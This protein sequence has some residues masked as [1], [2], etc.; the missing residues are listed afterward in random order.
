MR[1]R[2]G[3]FEF[4]GQSGTFLQTE[5]SA[6]TC[7]INTC[8]HI[9]GILGITDIKTTSLASK[10]T[11]TCP[12]PTQLC[13]LLTPHFALL[14]CT[15][16]DIHPTKE[17]GMRKVCRGTAAKFALF[18]FHWP[19][20]MLSFLQNMLSF[21]R[22]QNPTSVNCFPIKLFKNCNIVSLKVCTMVM[23]LA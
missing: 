10:K 11:L 8:L 20:N 12:N 6:F 2:R 4:W 15:A 22:R 16:L 1:L 23:S 18:T 3:S 17:A 5:P 9:F 19:S 7:T 21:T 14:A 13:Q